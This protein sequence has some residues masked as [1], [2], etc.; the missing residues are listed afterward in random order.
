MFKNLSCEA[1]GISGRDSEIIELVLSHGFKGLDLELADFAE[2]VKTQGMARASRLIT[3]ARLKI[4]SF[5]LP[6]R[7]EDDASAYQ[8]DLEKLPPLAEIAQQMGC[9]R[10]VTQIEPGNDSRPYHEGFEFHRRRFTEIANALAPYK[11]RLGIGF[12]APRSCR[13]GRAFQFI[14]TVGELLQL[15]QMIGPGSV[16][17]AIDTW[18]WHLGGGTL[19]Q[20]R[21]LSADKIVT[22][23]LADAPLDMTA[24]NA[25]LSSRRL[26]GE[27]G[28][29]DIPA[30]LATLAELRYD[31]PV[32]LEP[33]RSQ[34][35]GLGR[36]KIVKQVGAALDE[37]WK[38]AGLNMAG[39]LAPVPGR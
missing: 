32:T 15:L 24:A 38:A 36:E 8:A 1:L 33:D 14:Q 35:A 28:A 26:P 12:L 29:I 21:A 10:A 11:I 18:H 23:T 39:K 7:W 13:D 27:G 16:G 6:V 37:V 17:L 3:S 34:F 5:R 2:Q 9:T 30:V 25:Q 31:G 4:G 20:L 22:V 19:E